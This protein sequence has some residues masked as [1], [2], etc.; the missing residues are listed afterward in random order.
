MAHA[1]YSG[2]NIAHI[3]GIPSPPSNNQQLMVGSKK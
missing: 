1:S 3:A 2:Q